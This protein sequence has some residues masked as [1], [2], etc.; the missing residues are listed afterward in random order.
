MSKGDKNL[1]Q[2]Y[3]IGCKRTFDDKSDSRQG[4]I[5]CMDSPFGFPLSP[6]T[7]PCPFTFRKEW[8]RWKN[9][10][11]QAIID[12]ENSKPKPFLP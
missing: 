3:C 7:A 1:M 5:T 9:S 6:R 4:F 8:E 10:C 11:L 2:Y 12:E